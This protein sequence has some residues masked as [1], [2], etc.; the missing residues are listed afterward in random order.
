MLDMLPETVLR[1][2]CKFYLS[3]G[4]RRRLSST[5]RFLNKIVE[6][7]WLDVY[8]LTLDRSIRE[9]SNPKDG[10]TALGGNANVVAK[11]FVPTDTLW[12]QRLYKLDTTNTNCAILKKDYKELF[13]LFKKC[14]RL[15]EIK[16]CDD[17]SISYTSLLIFPYKKSTITFSR[18]TVEK[19]VIGASMMRL[20]CHF[21]FY[22]VNVLNLSFTMFSWHD[23]EEAAPSFSNLIELRMEHCRIYVSHRRAW[24]VE[25]YAKFL[26]TYIIDYP[27][28]KG[29]MS[30]GVKCLLFSCCSIFHE[31]Q[32]VYVGAAE[33][34][35]TGCIVY[36]FGREFPGAFYRIA[37][38][39]FAWWDS[40]LTCF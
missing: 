19:K 18:S 24:N 25:K 39:K 7:S 13:F 29:Q 5:C 21:T 27:R 12:P 22:T 16:F 35:S 33:F 36:S 31:L 9:L 40:V 23:F 6:K 38:M 14:A 34:Q 3:F 17:T 30:R 1:K 4:D 2:L 37:D 15:R 26:S 8:R 20:L 10:P 32:R 11:F 28:I